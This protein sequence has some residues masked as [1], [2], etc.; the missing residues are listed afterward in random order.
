MVV[1]AI[2]SQK[3]TAATLKIKILSAFEQMMQIGQQGGGQLKEVKE[4]SQ[5]GQ[6]QQEILGIMHLMCEDMKLVRVG[7]TDIEK[8]ESVIIEWATQLK[9][10]SY[11]TYY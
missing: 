3:I 9:K 4:A 2:K 5:L 10:Q 6:Y 1:T 11:L 7:C 8:L